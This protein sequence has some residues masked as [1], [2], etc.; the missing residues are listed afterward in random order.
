MLH[1]ARPRNARLRVQ[2]EPPPRCLG[3]AQAL[4]LRPVY[5]VAV[6]DDDVIMMSSLLSV[7]I[8][9]ARLLGLWEGDS[10]ADPLD[11]PYPNTSRQAI[12]LQ[13]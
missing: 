11:S 13:V 6:D 8:G 2:V 3:N 9:G 4:L 1:T 5:H 7:L 12:T 10:E